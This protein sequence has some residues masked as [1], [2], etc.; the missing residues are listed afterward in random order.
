[1]NFENVKTYIQSGNVVFET[2]ERSDDVL[3]EKIERELQKSLGFEVRVMPRAI[4][5]LEDIAAHNPFR[6][7]ETAAKIYV[8][9]LSAAPDAE[10]KNSLLS[11]ENDFEVFRFRNREMYCLIR[12]D[13]PAKDLFSNNFIEKHLKVAATTRNITTVNKILLLK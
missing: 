1:M 4:R 11:F 2:A 8:C 6:E 13:N 5:E 10:L 3:A 9:F 12:P 7:D